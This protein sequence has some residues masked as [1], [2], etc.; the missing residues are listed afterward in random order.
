MN[1][2]DVWKKQSNKEGKNIVVF[3]TEML[4]K[5]KKDRLSL[6][7]NKQKAYIYSSW[8]QNISMKAL[9]YFRLCHNLLASSEA[10]TPILYL[11]SPLLSPLS[12]ILVSHSAANQRLS[13]WLHGGLVSSPL[14][15][16][17]HRQPDCL[18]AHIM[19]LLQCCFFFQNVR[20]VTF[21]NVLQCNLYHISLILTLVL[22]K[23]RRFKWSHLAV[24]LHLV[25]SDGYSLKRTLIRCEECVISKNTS[26]LS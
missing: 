17:T 16:I 20:T 11:T 7:R 12:T 24:I 23:C 9:P 4:K 13:H 21:S 19:A 3:E 15:S 10:L 14:L 22:K 18:S 25:P 1:R 8:T 6:K 26:W 2:V 5:H